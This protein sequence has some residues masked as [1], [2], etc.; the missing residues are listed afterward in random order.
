MPVTY[1]FIAAFGLVSYMAL[2]WVIVDVLKLPSQYVTTVRI[3]SGAVGLLFAGL[4]LWWKGKRGGGGAQAGA[5]ALPSEADDMS[6]L[7]RDAELRLAASP[8]GSDARIS[9]LPVIFGLG[10][11]NSAKTSTFVNCGAEPEL[12]GGHVYQEGYIVPTRAVNVWFARNAVMLEAGGRLLEDG[13][14]WNALLQRLKPKRLRSLFTQKKQAP[15]S[16]IVYFDVET[17]MKPGAQ[18]SATLVARKLNARLGEVS[19]A[20][21]IQLP[22]YVI[23]TRCD[24]MPFFQEFVGNFSEEEARQVVGVTVPM[25]FNA[26]VGVYAEEE[27]RRLTA[28]FNDLFLGLADQRPVQLAREVNSQKLP[29]VYEFPRE[30]RKIRALAVQFL[31]DL[32]RPSQLQTSPYLRGFYFSGVRPVEVREVVQ[33]PRLQQAPSRGAGATGIF[34]LQPDPSAAA[35]A[36]PQSVQVRRIPQWVFLSRLFNDVILRDQIAFQASASGVGADNARRWLLGGGCLLALILGGLWTN[37]YFNNRGLQK[38]VNEAVVGIGSTS[39]ES[40]EL[41]PV[42]ALR[43]LESLRQSVELLSRYNREGA[44][45]SLRYGLYTGDALLPTVRRLYFS[46]FNQL[47]FGATQAGLLDFMRKVPSTPG[48]NDD[49]GYAYDTLKGYLITTYEYKRST[50]LFLSP[51]LMNRWAGRRKVDPD[52]LALAQKQFD[53]YSEELKYDNPFSKESDS[54]AIERTRRY[55]AQFAATERI[56]LALLATANQKFPP[57]NYNKQF[58]GSGQVIVNNKDIGGAFSKEGWPFMQEAIKNFE[59]YFAGEEWVLGPQTSA[60]L[61]HA[62]IEPILLARYKA[63]YIGNWRDYLKNSTV[64]RY[65]SV[66]D[67]SRKLGLMSNNNSFLLALFCLASENISKASEEGVK[68]AFQ[69]V[70]F[71]TPPGCLDRYIGGSNQ[72]YMNALVALQSSL[73]AVVRAR[74]PNDPSVNATLQLASSAK[75]SVRQLAQNFRIDKEN[76]IDQQSEKI[77]MDPITY[78]EGLLGR[79]AP[80]QINGEAR[81]FCQDFQGVVNKYPFNTSSQID[82][83]LD[84]INRVFKPGSGTLW[85]FYDQNLKTYL[86][87]QGSQYAPNTADATIRVTPAFVSFFNRAASFSDALYRTNPQGDPLVNY[88]MRAV[89]SEGIQSLTLTLE[90]QTLK[91]NAAGGQQAN[92]QWPG[93]RAHEA[94]MAGSL[95]GPEFGLLTYNGLWAVFR[96]FGDADRWQPAGAG[97]NFE[98]VPRQGQSNQPMTLSSGKPLTVRYFLEMGT[99][100]PIFRKNYLAGFNCV[101]QAAQ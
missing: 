97:F 35:P 26:R 51:L 7:F 75:I 57:V 71:V 49:Y 39:G 64:L 15:R 84:E 2:T 100:E 69:P 20:L 93:Q 99:Q 10:E 87:K 53:F 50:K 61:D 81:R 73:D 6:P 101:S 86:I 40:P 47:L 31:I 58:Q 98:W 17:L 83:T 34:A 33:A 54:A 46:R 80:A 9:T 67:A 8:L 70:S 42:E 92:F 65:G 19:R 30:F 85:V 24:R 37:S 76:H 11:A 22:V 25:A 38:Q 5:A 96:F 27:T 12:I 14:R 78:I 89:A 66:E 32:C 60:A 23:F 95:G 21:G 68:N 90:G 4:F 43:R 88:S 74:N 13:N 94:R 56:Y 16:A 41:P 82:A 3:L 44:P 36:A 62:K 63:D 18:E 1:Y 72:N 91:S 28:V 55:L 77:L 52:R 59:K 79:L 48:P 29:G 45:W